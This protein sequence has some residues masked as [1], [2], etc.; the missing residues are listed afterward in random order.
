MVED[1][2]ITLANNIRAERNRANKN[3][4]ETAEV[5]G[6]TRQQYYKYEQDASG[7]SMKYALRLARY[8]NCNINAFLVNLK[9]TDSKLN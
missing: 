1:W 9:F 2:G 5:L 7:I 3:Q 4:Q 8:F 6:I